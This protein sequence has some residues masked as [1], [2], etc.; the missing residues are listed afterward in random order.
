M[1][2]PVQVFFYGIKNADANELVALVKAGN[3]LA[4]DELRS[5]LPK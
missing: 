1:T 5:R 2:E 3:E 4:R